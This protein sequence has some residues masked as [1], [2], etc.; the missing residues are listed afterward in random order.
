[1]EENGRRKMSAEYQMRARVGWI[2]RWSWTG[3]VAAWGPRFTRRLHV[4]EQGTILVRCCSEPIR[5]WSAVLHVL[6][7]L[8][9]D[10]GWDLSY[11]SSVTTGKLFQRSLEETDV[12]W[13]H[14]WAVGGPHWGS[15]ESGHQK[16]KFLPM[17]RMEPRSFYPYLVCVLT[18][19]QP[20]SESQSLYSVPF[21]PEAQ[22][23]KCV[24]Y[25]CTI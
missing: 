4:T 22:I 3:S 6:K 11:I 14:T 16:D 20:N 1:M 12:A 2:L 5:Y 23:N 15:S 18:A 10:I 13:P 21:L 8:P 7:V 24:T 9:P 17:P 19:F 25:V